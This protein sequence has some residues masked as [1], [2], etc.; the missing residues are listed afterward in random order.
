M[1][2]LFEHEVAPVPETLGLRTYKCNPSDLTTTPHRQ[3]A[4]IT[5]S[6]IRAL[7]TDQISSLKTVP[8]GDLTGMNVNASTPSITKEQIFAWMSEWAK[9]NLPPV[10]PNWK[11]IKLPDAQA[12]ANWDKQGGTPMVKSFDLASS[13]IAPRWEHE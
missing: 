13:K 9:D 5:T 10:P 6:Q 11:D 8:L 7:T 12:P 4:T 1:K 3:M 2:T